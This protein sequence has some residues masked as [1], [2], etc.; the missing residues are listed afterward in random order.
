M[1]FVHPRYCSKQ[2]GNVHVRHVR[3]PRW[4]GIISYHFSKIRSL[5]AGQAWRLSDASWHTAGKV[6]YREGRKGLY[7]FLREKEQLYKYLPLNDMPPA[8]PIALS[9]TPRVLH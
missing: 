7:H 5:P 1:T 9:E 8:V 6:N 3:G 4:D 2:R